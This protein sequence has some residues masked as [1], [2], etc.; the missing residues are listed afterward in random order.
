MIAAMPLLMIAVAILAGSGA[1]LTEKEANAY[2]RAGA[3]GKWT[4]TKEQS[5]SSFDFL[6][7]EIEKTF[8]TMTA[9]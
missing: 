1:A 8:Q 5:Y 6:S 4:F 3:I 9:I 2:G 7:N